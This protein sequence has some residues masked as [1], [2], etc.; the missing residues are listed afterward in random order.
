MGS[1]SVVNGQCAS[2]F[3]FPSWPFFSL[4]RSFAVFDSSSTIQPINTQCKQHSVWGGTTE[5][6]SEEC[7]SV[8]P[9]CCVVLKGWKVPVSSVGLRLESQCS[10]PRPC[11]IFTHT[12]SP[13]PLAS[14]W[15]RDALQSPQWG[16][17]SQ[18]INVWEQWSMKSPRTEYQQ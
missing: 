14:G 1:Q 12:E 16:F 18:K 17:I 11:I 5:T 10:C 2:L 9:V 4:L 13:V 15:Y 8:K 3:N 6:Q 7:T